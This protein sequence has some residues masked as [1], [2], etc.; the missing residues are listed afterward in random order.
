MWWNSLH[1]WRKV[2]LPVKL[3]VIICSLI[4]LFTI[5]WQLL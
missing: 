5:A 4:V 2:S 3:T 1:Q